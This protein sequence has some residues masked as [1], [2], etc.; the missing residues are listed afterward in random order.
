MACRSASSLPWIP[1]CAL[2][3]LMPVSSARAS[4]RRSAALIS[5][6]IRDL[7]VAPFAML[8]TVAFTPMLSVRMGSQVHLTK[9]DQGGRN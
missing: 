4:R 2:T 7:G 1:M 6:S 8:I 9:E 5:F 3:Q